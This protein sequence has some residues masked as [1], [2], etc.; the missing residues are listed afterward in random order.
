MQS[1][2]PEKEKEVPKNVNC[3]QKWNLSKIIAQWWCE[4]DVSHQENL[5][6]GADLVKM[7]A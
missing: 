5:V 7:W 2:E 1:H 4:I 3:G 6:L